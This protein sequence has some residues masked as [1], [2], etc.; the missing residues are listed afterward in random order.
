M[1]QELSICSL[2]LE[3]A[4]ELVNHM[5]Q[6][7]VGDEPLAPDLPVVVLVKGYEDDGVAGPEGG[8]RH[9]DSDC[10]QYRGQTSS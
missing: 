4:P 3:P 5:W 10:L 7:V 8:V 9:Q 1:T 6:Q 2:H